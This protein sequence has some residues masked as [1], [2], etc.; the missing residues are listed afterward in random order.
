M[1]AG[2]I[3]E[4]MLTSLL[5]LISSSAWTRLALGRSE[6]TS[7]QMERLSRTDHL[8]GLSNRR[9]LYGSIE[10]LMAEAAQAADA[11]GPADDPPATPP[12][13]FSLAL[14]DIDHFKSVNDSFGHATGDAVLCGV[15]EVLESF[16]RRRDLAGRWGG[17]EFVLVLPG[18][19]LGTAVRIAE[20][21]RQ[22]IGA[23]RLLPGRSVTASF[24]VTA[25]QPGDTLEALIGRADAAMYRAKH[26]G[27]NRVEVGVPGEPSVLLAAQEVGLPR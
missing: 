10:A 16:L 27:R 20:R 3:T 18:V 4:L 9:S 21:L 8:T 14:L 23:A 11:P 12:R 13:T 2:L 15:A 19:T 7:L 22:G 17:E 6:A 5:A 1:L 25:W 24:G 26:G